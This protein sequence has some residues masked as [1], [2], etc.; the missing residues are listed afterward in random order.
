VSKAADKYH[1]DFIYE[2]YK[3][4]KDLVDFPFISLLRRAGYISNTS[5]SVKQTKKQTLSF[6]TKTEAELY[7]YSC[8]AVVNS[9]SLKDGLN[10]GLY[11]DVCEEEN[12]IKDSVLVKKSARK[13]TKEDWRPKDRIQH[14]DDFYD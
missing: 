14:E 9:Q 12:E 1:L 2:I 3:G 11:V 13:I 6:T 7:V 5:K 4:N 10:Q 8:T